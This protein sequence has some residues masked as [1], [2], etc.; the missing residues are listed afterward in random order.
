MRHCLRAYTL[1][2]LSGLLLF[3]SLPG[4]ANAEQETVG[5]LEHATITQAAFA[6]EAKIDTGADNSSINA[7]DAEVYTRGGKPWVRFFVQ[8]KLGHSVLIDQ[9]IVKTT[10]IKMK[11]GNLQQRSVIELDICLGSLQKRTQVNLIDRSH[12]KHQLLIGRSFLSP[13]YLVDTSQTHR[14]NSQCQPSAVM[15]KTSLM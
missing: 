14:V 8:N 1:G 5:W 11:D 6:I 9:P 12:F 15:R 3:I 13:D 7:R 2:P 4:M 10:R